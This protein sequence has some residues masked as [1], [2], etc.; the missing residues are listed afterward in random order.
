MVFGELWKGEAILVLRKLW[1]R[2]AYALYTTALTAPQTIAAT[3][4]NPRN[5]GRMP[6]APTAVQFVARYSVDKQISW[7]SRI[8]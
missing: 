4:R 7:Q 2:M 5:S 1:G 8:T 6:Y 3:S